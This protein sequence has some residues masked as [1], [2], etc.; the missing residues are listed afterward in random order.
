SAV[1]SECEARQRGFYCLV[2]CSRQAELSA[3]SRVDRSGAAWTE[4]DSP[5]DELATVAVAELVADP[6]PLPPD[7]NPVAV[8]LA[9][10]GSA[11]SRRAVRDRLRVVAALLAGADAD[12][13]ALPWWRLGYQH[14]QAV[15]ARLAEAYAPA[16]CNLALAALRR[17]LKECWR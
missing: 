12:P 1:R 4:L 16:T 8:Y 14:T 10:L 13:Y 6:R 15:R 9:S 17:V 5:M 2:G 3:P 7:R 11:N